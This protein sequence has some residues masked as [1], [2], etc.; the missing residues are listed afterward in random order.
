MMS[1]HTKQL[2]LSLHCSCRCTVAK[3]PMGAWL[4]C[5]SFGQCTCT[6]V[7]LGLNTDLCSVVRI[8]FSTAVIQA[9]TA[10][11]M[12]TGAAKSKVSPCMDIGDTCEQCQRCEAPSRC[13]GAAKTTK[14]ML[15]ALPLPCL[16]NGVCCTAHGSASCCVHTS[17]DVMPVIALLPRLKTKLA[18]LSN[19]FSMCS[20][21]L[22]GSAVPSTLN[23]SSSEMKKN[24]QC[25]D[26]AHI[27]QG[28][29]QGIHSFMSWN[30]RG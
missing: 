21:M 1:Q 22:V 10:P 23:S 26:R 19:S 18:Q 14:M 25:Q 12:T 17:D 3:G 8:S 6:G 29:S 15:A 13:C 24:L 28:S 30:G 7:I 16:P 5:R 27:M 11:S 9:S 4:S 20:W 2:S